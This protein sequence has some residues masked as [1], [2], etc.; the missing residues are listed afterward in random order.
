MNLKHFQLSEF[1]CTHTGRNE[2]KLEFLQ[3]LDQLRDI[4]GFPFI[5]TSGYRD[6]TH[7]IEA[8]KDEPGTHAQGIAADIRVRSGAQAYT[9]MKHAFALG[10]TGIALGNGFVHLDTRQTTAV[11]WRY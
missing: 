9:L 7:P 5:V 11:T 3:K 4:C 8:R 2:M 10:F 6:P 1:N